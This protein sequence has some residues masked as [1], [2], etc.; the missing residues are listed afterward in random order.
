[1]TKVKIGQTWNTLNRENE[2]VTWKMKRNDSAV[3]KA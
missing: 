1:M 3:V 2:E